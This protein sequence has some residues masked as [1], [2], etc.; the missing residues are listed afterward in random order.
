VKE[1]ARTDE[2]EPAL[3]SLSRAP[4]GG[5]TFGD[6]MLDLQR[7]AGNRAVGRMVA[8]RARRRHV[9]RAKLWR[10]EAQGGGRGAPG[11]DDDFGPGFYVAFDQYLGRRYAWDRAATSGDPARAQVLAADVAERFGPTL[12]LMTDPRWPQFLAEETFDGSGTRWADVLPPQAHNVNYYKVFVNFLNRFGIDRQSYRTIVGPELVRGGVQMCIIDP[13]L[14]SRVD[15]ALKVV[16]TSGQMPALDGPTLTFA[17]GGPG[18]S[19]RAITPWPEPGENPLSAEDER[20]PAPVTRPA[21]APLVLQPP[22][23]VRSVPAPPQ[24]LDQEPV[25]TPTTYELSEG[26][27]VKEDGRDVWHEE[28]WARFEVVNGNLRVSVRTSRTTEA[29]VLERSPSL[30]YDEQAR[31]AIDWFASQGNPVERWPTEWSFMKPGEMSTNLKVFKEG[32]AQGLSEEDAARLTPTGKLAIAHGFTEVLVL[33]STQESDTEIK[34]SDEALPQGQREL[35]EKQRV[36]FSRSGAPSPG[37]PVGG[38]G[39]GGGPTPRPIL[40]VPPVTGIP[41]RPTGGGTAAPTI[42]ESPELRAHL[43]PAQAPVELAQLPTGGAARTDAHGLLLDMVG[44]AL[45]RINDEEQRRRAKAEMLALE[46]EIARLREQ[47]P[48]CGVLLIPIY[49]QLQADGHAVIKP[50]PGLVRIVIGVG[51]DPREADVNRLN[52]PASAPGGIFEHDFEAD[53][54]WIPALRPVDPPPPA[55]PFPIVALATFAS[56]KP[57]LTDVIWAGGFDDLGETTLYVEGAVEPR[58]YVLQLPQTIKAGV[59]NLRD[60][61][62]DTYVIDQ[63]VRAG[64]PVAR[65]DVYV[66]WDD[67]VGAAIFP[68]DAATAKLFNEAPA[69]QRWRLL[70][71]QRPSYTLIRWISPEQIRVLQQPATAPAASPT[72]PATP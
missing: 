19:G 67:D 8:A 41:G 35:F 6:R 7:R 16:E 12:N 44:A 26:R 24:R 65:L 60:P 36:V 68:A 72:P 46:P 13:E 30:R 25:K 29:G 71:P 33:G 48:D 31:A 23:G 27:W 2:H 4:A 49:R 28:Y 37:R 17:G 21:P 10:G 5:G 51:R 55:P 42:A 69:I 54:T 45:N 52:P 63:D 22:V 59:P 15:A 56:R 32:L 47:R 38:G 40:D 64:L 66:P 34:P 57:T 18:A 9:A 62:T 50:G 20:A 43:G 3:A 14:A 1:A 58:F 61:R 70:V 53:H 11:F 39:S